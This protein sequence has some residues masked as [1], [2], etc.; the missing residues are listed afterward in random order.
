MTEEPQEP[1]SGPAAAPASADAATERTA[2]TRTRRSF[3]TLGLAGLAGL[4]GWRYLLH[5][6]DADG[7]PGGLRRVL[8]FNAR[9]SNEYYRS[10]RLAPEF[11]K[12]RARPPRVNG[13]V[14]LSEDFDPATWQLQVLGYAP[15]GTAPRRQQ[16]TLA[17]LQALPRTEFTTELKCIE[18]WSTVVTWAG[19]RLADLLARYPL[20]T[21][22]GRPIADQLPPDAAPYVSLVT[23]D[24]Q[25]Y[26]GLELE[27]A[28]H[29]QT[30]LC[31][32][33]NGQPLTLAHGAPLR[34]VTPLKYGIK[35]LK[36]LGTLSFVAQRPAD[37]WAERGYDWHAGH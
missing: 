3:I 32:E 12:A 4:A 27:S 9:L 13:H 1:R 6:P 25:Y 24:E 18:G 36:R 20:A 2:A 28:L 7:L 15:A 14:G 26:V 17:Q 33:M 8:D 22:S 5:T 11:A 30:L 35:Y 19:V 23:P 29:P 34:L 10:A 16:F 37:Y 21:A 31:Y